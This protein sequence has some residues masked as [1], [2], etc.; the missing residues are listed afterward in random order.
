MLILTVTNCSVQS[1]CVGLH[2]FLDGKWK[3]KGFLQLI[4][5]T[6]KRMDESQETVFHLSRETG[7]C[8]RAIPNAESTSRVSRRVYKNFLCR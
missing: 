3:D 8:P 6:A 4:L 2:P 1:Y 5:E 7:H